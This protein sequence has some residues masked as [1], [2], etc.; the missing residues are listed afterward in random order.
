LIS[1]NPNVTSSTG[2]Y[3]AYGLDQTNVSIA[4]SALPTPSWKA[5]PN[6]D[7]M[8]P[9]S[10]LRSSVGF[11]PHG[12]VWF[13]ASAMK[14]LGGRFIWLGKDDT[15]I[16]T[17]VYNGVGAG[18][19]YP[20]ALSLTKYTSAGDLVSEVDSVLTPTMGLTTGDFTAYTITV[21][22]P[23]YYAL[24][25]DVD[26]ESIALA[27]NTPLLT[28]ASVAV[29]LAGNGTWAHQCAPGIENILGTT[30]EIREIGAGV[31]VT[32]TSQLLLRG[33]RILQRQMEPGTS[34]FDLTPGNVSG[35][36]PSPAANWGQA[37]VSTLR[38]VDDR[39]AEDGSYAY[40]KPVGQEEF[41][42]KHEYKTDKGQIL[43]SSWSLDAE[44]AYLYWSIQAPV[45]N[46]SATIK[47]AWNYEAVTT[48]ATREQA[49][50][51]GSAEDMV[52]VQSIMSKMG[53]YDCNPN[54]FADI[55]E[56]IKK[57]V[58]SVTSFLGEY[59]PSILSGAAKIGAMLA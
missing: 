31:M 18:F 6:T 46:L 20:D 15:V 13:C 39:S 1:Y 38:D 28:I 53:Q 50:P 54:S 27:D 55:W 17:L 57:G 9:I 14:S 56:S 36:Y 40:L 12:S 25:F 41:A 34:W 35:T 52:R 32:N 21:T 45:G 24:S 2:S 19:W 22:S 8:L 42:L 51:T 16:T 3:I 5:S 58:G 33:G 47:A 29:D 37:Y 48:D 7:R 44:R 43:D 10:F 4:S 30:P 23:G 26:F 49:R 59:G 11:A